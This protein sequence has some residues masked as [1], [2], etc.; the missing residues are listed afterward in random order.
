MNDVAFSLD[1]AVPVAYFLIKPHVTG[2]E[3]YQ[4]AGQGMPLY[5]ERVRVE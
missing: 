2:F 4:N 1:Y 5:I 3:W